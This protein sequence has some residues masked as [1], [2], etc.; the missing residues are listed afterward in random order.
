[1]YYDVFWVFFVVTEI[2]II[3]K[4]KNLLKVT[5]ICKLLQAMNTVIMINM[6]VMFK[7]I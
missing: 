1:M 6:L 3:V 2:D 5:S 7:I 4:L